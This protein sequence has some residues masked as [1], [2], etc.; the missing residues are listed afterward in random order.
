MKNADIKYQLEEAGC[1]L[2]GGN[3]TSAYLKGVQEYYNNTGE[4][5]DIVECTSCGFR[6]TSPRPTKDTIGCFYPDS[7]GYYQPVSEEVLGR[8]TFKRRMLKAVLKDHYGYEFDIA[9]NRAVTYILKVFFSRTISLQHIPRFVT[10]GRLLDI[11]CSWGGYLYRMK[12]FGWDVYGTELNGK[13]V[14]H[15]REQLGLANVRHG[16]F[17]DLSWDNDF[18][19]AVNMSMVLEHLY[20]P[21]KCLQMIHSVIKKDGQLILSVPDI[22]GFEARFYKEK[23]YSLHVPQHLYH[24]TPETITR[25]L[26]K[27]GFRVE[28]IVHQNFDRDLVASSGYLRNRLLFKILHN[29]V[30]RRTAVKAAVRLLSAFGMTS[31]MSVYA[32]R[33]DA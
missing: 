12:G 1:L 32:R 9:V 33:A 30:I 27:A 19:D 4:R 29:P 5:F 22:S 24:F 16:F 2:C 8:D 3:E 10:G 17:E 23:C 11:G 6:F 7:A 25:L 28:K 21:L 14:E 18:F 26:E 31:R 20:D 15:A 13:A